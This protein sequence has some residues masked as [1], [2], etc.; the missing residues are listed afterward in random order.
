MAGPLL[1]S[2]LGRLPLIPS[3][4]VPSMSSPEGP[5]YDLASSPEGPQYE[6]PL[7][8][9]HNMLYQ[10]PQKVPSMNPLKVPICYISLP[11]RYPV[12]YIML[13]SRSS[14]CPCRLPFRSPVCSRRHSSDL[15]SRSWYT[16]A[17]PLPLL[18]QVPS[19]L[20]QAPLRPRVRSPLCHMDHH[21]QDRNQS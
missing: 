16:I 12:C 1:S 19:V 9:V 14:V 17:A 8:K 15:P 3:L 10:A 2:P 4:K 6:S 7:L 18:L 13:P 11:W 21:D 20:L 5:Q